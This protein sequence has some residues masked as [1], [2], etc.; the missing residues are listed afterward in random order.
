MADTQP[1]TG[2][3][4]VLHHILLQLM[5]Y[6]IFVYNNHFVVHLHLHLHILIGVGSA[7]DTT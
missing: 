7:G 1:P 3:R 6:C 5:I 4:I 2:S